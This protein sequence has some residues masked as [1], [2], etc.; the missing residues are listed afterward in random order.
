M[1]IQ[2][3]AVALVLTFGIISLPAN[4]DDRDAPR[5]E[6]IQQV[7]ASQLDAFKSNDAAAAFAFAAPDVQNHFGTPELFMRMVRQG[8]HPLSQPRYVEFAQLVRGA[9]GQFAQHVI[10]ESTDGAFVMA[11]YPM[12][13]DTEGHWRIAGCYLAPLARKS[14]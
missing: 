4:A 6:A 11:V 10:V 13:Q 5:A 7:I 12:T 3:L 8:Y 9:D 1:R 14:T 2:M